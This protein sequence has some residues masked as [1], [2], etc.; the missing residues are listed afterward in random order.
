MVDSAGDDSGSWDVIDVNGATEPKD[1]LP[2][3]SSAPADVSIQHGAR[4][5][6]KQTS[7]PEPPR[8]RFVTEAKKSLGYSS[9][10]A[11]TYVEG[12]SSD[13][14]GA[15]Y[16]APDISI[17][18]PE[19]EAVIG[20]SQTVYEFPLKSNSAT[21]EDVEVGKVAVSMHQDPF[22]TSNH[23]PG[24]LT[25][26]EV[27]SSETQTP[28]GIFGG[29]PK[30]EPPTS[31]ARN[32]F[33]EWAASLQLGSKK[34]R[35]HEWWDGK[36]NDSYTMPGDTTQSTTCR[37]VGK[38]GF[39]DPVESEESFVGGFS[40]SDGSNHAG[41]QW[42]V[43]S[44][45][46]DYGSA[47]VGTLFLHQSSTSSS[48]NFRDGTAQTDPI[49]K[50]NGK[51]ERRFFIVWI[52]LL[53]LLAIVLAALL[54]QKN[55][56]EKAAAAAAAGAA[57]GGGVLVPPPVVV[58]NETTAAPSSQPSVSPECPVRTKPFS[59]E[60]IQ[61]D[62]GY[63]APTTSSVTWK[64]KEACSG[65]TL[66]QCFPCS[67][68]SLTLSR[69][70]G[71]LAQWRSSKPP[72]FLHEELREEITQCLPVNNEYIF[73]I[74]PTDDRDAC[75]GFDPLS[76][77]ISYDNVVIKDMA[78]GDTVGPESHMHFGERAIPCVSESSQTPS[79][80]PSTSSSSSP[81]FL[82]STNPPTQS[83]IIFLG[84][85]PE[86]YVPFQ[87]AYAVG[88]QV[89]LKG[90]VYKCISPSCGSYGFEPG[91]SASSLWR[92]GWEIVG[93]CS[94]TMSP[95]SHPTVSPTPVPSD[96]PTKSPTSSPTP[97]PTLRQRTRH[98]SHSPSWKPT[99]S[100]E[101]DFNLCL[102]IDMSGSVCNDGKGSECLEC[103]APFL[104]MFFTSEC[105][106]MFV[107]EDTCCNNFADVKE[108]SSNMVNLLDNFPADKSFS[109]VQF[110]T[111]AQLLNGLSSVTQT[112]SIIDRLDYTGG[113][114]NHADAIKMC[115]KNLQSFGNRKKFIM[116]IT[117]GKPSEPDYDP[118]GAALAA[119]SSAKYDGTF[120][121]PVFISPDNDWDAFAFM[122][123]LSSDGKV[124]DV[125]DFGSLNMLQ[126]RLVDQVSCL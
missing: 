96:A 66:V 125:T 49:E 68:G 21:K 48:A 23:E 124:F 41:D 75:C 82:P 47:R 65:E 109:V 37:E 99:C 61:H 118:E 104:P 36:T 11:G 8:W 106:D 19:K 35:E 70:Q 52:L 103:R 117:D 98:P 18:K 43:F 101:H 56:E 100:T 24:K 94:G 89:G 73:E 14:L 111:N 69:P 112:L 114:T 30:A 17:Y 9:I 26:R 84:G 120:I 113:L 79:F 25:I 51:N 13:E 59:I 10:H 78:S 53:L 64:L 33:M 67:L 95:T 5:T 3:S 102:A 90:I 32:P 77:I 12:Q 15:K 81:S 2:S 121:I 7:T 62:S 54:G 83:P 44:D 85:C 123:K 63:Y 60:H 28:S 27:K 71:P 93:S 50:D 110:A 55:G 46:D 16:V 122:R 34:D 6:E 45:E 39:Y 86:T 1:A 20:A 58:T 80:A 22:S 97:S 31:E 40:R 115:Q 74:L 107:S 76:S 116:V 42:D 57:G 91:D 88:A 72:R 119:A 126:D 29:L 87:T 38:I 108:F 105:R 92:Q 4:P